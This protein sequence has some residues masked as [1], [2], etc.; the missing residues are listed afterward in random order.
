MRSLSRYM[1]KCVVVDVANGSLCFANSYAVPGSREER[2]T[3]IAKCLWPTLQS[4]VVLD[5]K[6]ITYWRGQK[7]GDN[8]QRG[9]S[10]RQW[11]GGAATI[12]NT[13]NV[14]LCFLLL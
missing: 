6:H 9:A 8:A 3:H 13:G 2:S 4:N 5:F 7:S 11:W 1:G 10:Q 12:G 14:L